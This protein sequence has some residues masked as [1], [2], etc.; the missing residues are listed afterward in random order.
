[1]NFKEFIKKFEGF[2]PIAYP[3][4]G[5]YAVGYGFNYL[6]PSW[7]RV[8]KNSSI[9]EEEAEKQLELWE[10][11]VFDIISK[12][13]TA[14]I[15][16]RQRDALGSLVY[17]IGA[18]NFYNSTVLQKINAG[19]PADE[20][21]EAWMRWSKQN[22]V[23]VPGLVVRHTAEATQFLTDYNPGGGET[24]PVVSPPPGLTPVEE[25]ELKDF[26]TTGASS[27]LWLLL[28]GA[29]LFAAF[30]LAGK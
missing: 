12:H 29:L 28:I 15:T 9:T 1:M 3:D 21:K 25:A 6:L 22:G 26:A 19:A 5:G 14:P 23:T 11:Y 24:A 30:Y 7:Q 8:Q 27:L 18:G 4:A 13:V 10:K 17:R 2:E 16:D 20:V